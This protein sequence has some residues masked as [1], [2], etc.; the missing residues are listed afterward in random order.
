MTT[1]QK[2]REAAWRYYPERTEKMAATVAVVAAGI[3]ALAA[4]V[5]RGRNP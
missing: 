5:W 4:W 2:L 1:S 3:A